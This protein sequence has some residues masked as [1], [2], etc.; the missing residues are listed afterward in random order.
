M[1]SVY[2]NFNYLMGMEELNFLSCRIDEE[3]AALVTFIDAVGNFRRETYSLGYP[4][5][6]TSVIKFPKVRNK[7]PRHQQSLRLSYLSRKS[8][9][10]IVFLWH[11]GNVFCNISK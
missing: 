2:S 8:L 7:Q 1:F 5:K 3:I 9:K 10:S 11:P 6:C 4:G